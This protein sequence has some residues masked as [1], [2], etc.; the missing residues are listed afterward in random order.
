MKTQSWQVR[1]SEA[2]AEEL[3]ALDAAVAQRVTARLTWLAA[4]ADTV[5]HLP[6]HGPLSGFYKLRAGD[7]RVVYALRPD[8]RT[9]LVRAI[10]HRRSVY[11]DA[12]R[13]G[14]G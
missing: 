14:L 6:L 9:L 13:H 4:Q 3:V 5:R 8:E 10:G 2:A 11:R 1:M 12:K 7:W